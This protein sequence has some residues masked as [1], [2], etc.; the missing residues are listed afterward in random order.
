MNKISLKD[1]SSK[2]H[3]IE[4]FIK[5]SLYRIDDDG[6]IYT[7]LTLNGQ[8]K[9]DKWREMGYKKSDGYV[10][11]RYKDDFLF[12]QR[13]IFRKFKGPLKPGHTIDH[14][15]RDN[16]NNHPKNLKQKTQGE[17]NKNKSKKYKKSKANIIKK[18]I[19][20]IKG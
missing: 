5:D 12:V 7:C 19:A 10:R 13:I 18:V 2:D 3:L 8:G 20:K 9:S 1:E 4:E 16:S 11:L 6:R 14:L 15:D 17:N